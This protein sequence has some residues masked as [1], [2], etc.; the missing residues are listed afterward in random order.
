MLRQTADPSS[1]FGLKAGQGIYTAFNP[2]DE[3][4]LTAK[5]LMLT[6]SIDK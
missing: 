5:G 6:S 3:D 2:M 4:I 1:R